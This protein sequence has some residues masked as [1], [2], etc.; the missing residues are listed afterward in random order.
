VSRIL[1]VDWGSRRIGLAVSDPTRRLARPLPTLRVASA[2]EAVERVAETARTEEAGTLLLGLPLHMGG[3]EGTSARRARKLG[4]SLAAFGF[5]VLYRD[6]RLS[7]ED[8][9]RW[10]SERGERRPPRERIDQ[11]SALLLLQEHLDA[12]GE[13]AHA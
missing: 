13:G 1:A 9:K 5:E 12:E 10:L 8:A 4:E 11:V 3:E 2:R 7:S 6:E